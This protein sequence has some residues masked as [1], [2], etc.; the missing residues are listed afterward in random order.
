MTTMSGLTP[1]PSEYSAHDRTSC[2]VAKNCGSGNRS[3]S[4]AEVQ[5]QHSLGNLL[6]K[7]RFLQQLWNDCQ[8]WRWSDSKWANTAIFR[9]A[10][11]RFWRRRN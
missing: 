2:Q 11:Q 9:F 1:L 10:A 7:S 3:N 4:Q 6:I 8:S 5:V